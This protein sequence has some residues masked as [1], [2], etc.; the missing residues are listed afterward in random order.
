MGGRCR[1]RARAQATPQAADL[2]RANNNHNDIRLFV[3]FGLSNALFCFAHQLNQH[4]HFYWSTQQ[5][6][7]LKENKSSMIDITMTSLSTP[8]HITHLLQASP[9]PHTF[10]SPFCTPGIYRSL[11]YFCEASSALSSCIFHPPFFLLSQLLFSYLFPA[12]KKSISFL[13]H[14]QRKGVLFSFYTVYRL[15]A[16]KLVFLSLLYCWCRVDAIYT[17][18]YIYGYFVNPNRCNHAATSII[19]VIPCHPPL[20][21]RVL[22]TTIRCPHIRSAPMG[23][24]LIVGVPRGY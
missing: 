6:T 11:I 1:F 5:Q 24:G 4:Q 15:R 21:R 23:G 19:I 17:H 22:P 9:L 12:A 20:Y 3:I 2:K 14:V 10:H 7:K 18:T 8:Y 16:K 13:L